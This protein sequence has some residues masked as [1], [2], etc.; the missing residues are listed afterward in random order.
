MMHF[1]EVI[2][3]CKNDNDFKLIEKSKLGFYQ[4]KLSNMRNKDG[5]DIIHTLAK[6][7]NI[8]YTIILDEFRA[9]IYG[10]YVTFPLIP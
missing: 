7:I 8:P 5:W 6:K 2:K 10:T 4:L 3:I 9:S 1:S